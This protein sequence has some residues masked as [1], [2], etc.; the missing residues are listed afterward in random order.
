MSD[1]DQ[2]LKRAERVLAEASRKLE[3]YAGPCSHCKHSRIGLM[4]RWCTHP[5]VQIAAFNATDHYAKGR[6]VECGYQ[7]DV[8]STYGEVVCGPDG[9]LFE[10]GWLAEARAAIFGDSK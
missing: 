5:V 3:T 4:D 10:R 6:I 2:Y 1:R 9:A 7:R 8:R